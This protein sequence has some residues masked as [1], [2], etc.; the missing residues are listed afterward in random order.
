MKCE[1]QRD[2]ERLRLLLV[3][4]PAAEV[5]GLRGM[6]MPELMGKQLQLVPPGRDLLG[7][8]TGEQDAGPY[9]IRICWIWGFV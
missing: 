1:C 2:R 5:L 4:N 9:E 7:Q 3:R 6:E 8:G